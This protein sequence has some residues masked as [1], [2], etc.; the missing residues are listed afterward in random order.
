MGGNEFFTAG[1]PIEI[2]G[3]E[4]ACAFLEVELCQGDL[5]LHLIVK[6]KRQSSDRGGSDGRK[7]GNIGLVVVDVAHIIQNSVPIETS[8]FK[9]NARASILEH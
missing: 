8:M 5:V 2:G 6:G 3:R 1:S 7:F 4:G 9:I